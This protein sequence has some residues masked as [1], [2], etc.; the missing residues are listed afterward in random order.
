MSYVLNAP[1][2]W[3]VPP[4][5]ESGIRERLEFLTD[6]IPAKNGRRQKRQLRQAPR[7]IFEFDVIADDQ[8]RRVA[9]ALLKDHGGKYWML[10]IWHDVQLLGESIAAGASSIPCLTDGFEFVQ[11]GFAL[12]W[13]AVNRWQLV[14]IAEINSDTLALGSMI[15][16]DWPV[17]TRLYPVRRARFTEQPDESTWTD[18]SGKR[19]VS[20]TIDEPCDWPAELPSASY[21]GYPVL[22]W[23]PDAGEDLS[24]T[25][26]R[27]L[28]TVDAGTGSVSVYDYP[29]RSFRSGALRWLVHGRDENTALRSLIY[30][31]AGRMQTVW[32]P[33]WN[34][35]LVV[36]ANVT[37][38]ALSLSVEW[39]GYTVFG[40]LQSNGRDIRI[41]LLDGSI[42]YR[43]ITSAA[44]AGETEVLGINAQLGTAITPQQI[45]CISFMTL[46]AMES[47]VIE[48]QHETD[49]DGLTVCA[50]S[51]IGE[52]HDV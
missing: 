28:E 29:G 4:D 52:R 9:D 44:E 2:P 21:L 35:D 26:N 27:Q 19:S 40:R 42:F 11:D 38:S 18:N 31:L 39:A 1:T 8:A 3:P 51:F 24:T 12:L 37:A 36:V 22:E 23:R 5:W 47:D 34:S 43:R 6:V 49:A 14:S 16:Q 33:T 13:L 45:R 48:L 50:T 10:P 25:F 20:M 7:R 32:V 41:E 46:S 30:G 17:G 15:A